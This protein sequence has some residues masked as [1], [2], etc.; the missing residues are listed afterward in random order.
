MTALAVALFLSSFWIPDC[1]DTIYPINF[2][3][4]T[5]MGV[6]QS[7]AYLFM[8][9]ED[10]LIQ[11]D[12][13]GN[14]NLPEKSIN[15]LQYNEKLFRSQIKI[16][17]YANL[18]FSIVL[19]FLIA[20]GS[21]MASHPYYIRS[22]TCTSREGEWKPITAYGNIFQILH[23]LMV[24]LQ[25]NVCQYVLIRLPRNDRIFDRNL[26]Q[27]LNERFA[28]MGRKRCQEVLECSTQE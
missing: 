6:V 11:K 26:V 2:I 17:Q 7:A 25:I 8:Y 9:C 21:V 13:R 16:L 23:Q 18:F 27:E 5:G 20:A 24:L 3:L 15:E 4:L 14:L 28:D 19:I 22:I 10:Y 12:N 1:Y